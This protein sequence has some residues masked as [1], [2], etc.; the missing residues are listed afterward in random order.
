MGAPE[1]EAFL[2]YLAAE[3]TISAST[4]KAALPALLYLYMEVVA[5][6]LSRMEQIHRPAAERRL[7]GSG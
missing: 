7:P 5:I 1:V 6:E 4:H 3:R 2:R